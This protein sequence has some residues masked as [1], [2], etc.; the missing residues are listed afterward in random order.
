MNQ[1][2]SKEVQVIV[3]LQIPPTNKRYSITK[4]LPKGFDNKK[5]DEVFEELKKDTWQLWEKLNEPKATRKESPVLAKDPE[6]RS[7]GCLMRAY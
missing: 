3:C 4:Q 5:F 6:A 2:Q 1:K 7:L